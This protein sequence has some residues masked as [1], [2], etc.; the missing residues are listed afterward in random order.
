MKTILMMFLALKLFWLIETA[1]I[2]SDALEISDTFWE[3]SIKQAW[4]MDIPQ[5]LRTQVIFHLFSGLA[6]EA[7]SL[8]RGP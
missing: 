4:I 1:D 8:I 5:S 3:V 2:A 6:Q 7:S